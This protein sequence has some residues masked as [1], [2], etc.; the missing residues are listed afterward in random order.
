LVDGVPAV[1]AGLGPYRQIPLLTK[2]EVNRIHKLRALGNAIV[3]PLAAE[4]IRA[5]METHPQW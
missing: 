2:G 5:W 4:V 1:L 3:P